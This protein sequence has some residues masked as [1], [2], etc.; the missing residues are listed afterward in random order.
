MIIIL[1]ILS[2]ITSCLL[3][4][5]EGLLFC[6]SV[7]DLH[8]S[9][10]WR[11]KTGKDI[12]VFLTVLRAFIFS[13]SVI[14]SFIFLGWLHALILTISTIL[15]FSFCHNGLYYH[16]RS[17]LDGAYKGFTDQSNTTTAKTSL[18]FSKR[19]FLFI[20]SLILIISSTQL[21]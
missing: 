13:G 14:M 9:D 21:K 5:L 15:A 3:G 11:D 18:S 2:L 20:I 10:Y 4:T 6:G 8:I 16:T 7:G 19:L 1:Y 17:K 12:H